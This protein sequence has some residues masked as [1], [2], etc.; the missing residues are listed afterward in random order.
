MSTIKVGFST[1]QSV[2]SRTIRWFTK[3]RVSHCFLVVEDSFLGCDVV[4]EATAGGFQV[5]RLDVFSSGCTIVRVITPSAPLLFGVQEATRWIG[6]RYDYVGLLGALV[7]IVAG[8]FKRKIKNP[9]HDSNSMFCSEAIVR[10][11]QAANYPGA[12]ALDPASTTPEALLEFMEG[13]SAS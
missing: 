11:L 1:G 13:Q 8:W 7:M 3:S 10:T 5:R 9:L 4:M 6:E 12:S 2:V